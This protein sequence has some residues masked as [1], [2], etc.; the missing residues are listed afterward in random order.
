MSDYIFPF[1]TCETPN[2]NGIAQP[3]SVLFNLINCVIIFFFLIKTKQ[4]YT[5]MLLFAIFCFELFHVF[6]HIIHIQGPIQINITHSLSY[7]INLSFLY[8]FYSYTNKLPSFWFILYLIVLICFD[9]YYIFNLN[10][11]YYLL[12]QSFIFISLLLYYFKYLPKFIK[13]TIYKIV[14]LVGIIIL[15]FLNE[16]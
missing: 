12:T 5:F 13:N 10:F 3:Y 16:K 6:S 11:I 1:D 14:F 9:I 7:F 8:L 4:N 15:L 2:K